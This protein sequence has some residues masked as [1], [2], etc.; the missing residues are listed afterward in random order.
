MFLAVERLARSDRGFLLIAALTVL[1]ALTLLGTTAYLLSSTDIKIGGNF[2]NSHAA[3]QVAMAGA[4]RARQA[5]RL[6]NLSSSESGSFSDELNSSARKGANGTLDGFSTTTDDQPLASGTLNGISYAAYL[7]NDS[8]DG[9]S[10]TSDV[11]GKV[12]ITSVATGPN[13]S[14][15]NVEIIVQ[16]NTAVASSPAVV[17]SKGDVTGNGSSLTITG[18]DACSEETALGPIYTKEPATTSLSGNPTL[19]GSP[20]TPQ[21]G[22]MDIDIAG[23]IDSFKA[24]ATT[25]LTDDQNGATHGSSTGYVTVYADTDDPPNNQGLKLQNVTGYGILLVKGDLTLGGGFNWNGIIY[26]T[27][28][29]TL[30]GGGGAGINVHGQIY[31]GTSTVTDV[32]LNGSNTLGYDSCAVKKALATQAFKV[33]SWKQDY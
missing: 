29:V 12:L 3:L 22:T 32:T 28:S 31:A 20:S 33:V 2:R 14:R 15:A 24:S 30:N 6:E 26:A 9:V 7:T 11:N 13:S 4:E 10:N 17:Y 5:L 25:V 19:S 23:I 1:S 18:N 8:A 21:Q 27:G 16:V